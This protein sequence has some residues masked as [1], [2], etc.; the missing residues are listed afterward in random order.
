MEHNEI[1]ELAKTISLGSENDREFWGEAPLDRNETYRLVGTGLLAM[2]L[3]YEALMA[4]C[5]KLSVENL[6]LHT[7]LIK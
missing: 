4:T 5:I 2:D 7:R 1:I 6:L 3:S